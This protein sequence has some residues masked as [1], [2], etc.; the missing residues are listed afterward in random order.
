MLKGVHLSLHIGP[1]VPVPAPYEVIEAL[2]SVD[3]TVNAGE[4]SGFQLQFELSNRSPLQAAFVLG[5][6]SPVPILRVIITATVN[7]S[8]T[9]LIDGV[10]TQQEVA[11]GLDG[12]STLS[13]TGEDLS[14]VMDLVQLNGIPYP[15]M[16]PVARAGLII[17]KYAALGVIPKVVPSINSVPPNPIDEIPRHKGTDLAYINELASTAGYVFYHEPGPR[18]GISFG[19]WGPYIKF[20]PVQPALTIN[21]DA[22]NNVES[23]SCKY[24]SGQATL[25]IAMIQEPFTKTPIPIPVGSIGPLN[26]PLGAVPPIPSR[27]E[28]LNETSKMNFAQAAEFALGKASKS[29]NVVSASGS[30]DVIR[31]GQVLQPRKLVGVRGAGNAFDGLYYVEGV[32]HK[33]KRGEYKQDFRLSRNAL[34]PNVSSVPA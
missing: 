7:S 15:A 24:A 3:V 26:P 8:P 5:G 16:P 1:A 32:T 6:G 11:P 2:T 22:H 4:R 30:L 12:K 20:G 9:V 13:V 14:Y 28:V 17:G 19:Y 27:V 23:L 21:M 18:P 29:Q 31:Y 34:V 33:I 25:P 10:V